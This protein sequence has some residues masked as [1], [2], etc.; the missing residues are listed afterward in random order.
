MWKLRRLLFCLPVLWLATDLRAAEPEAD[1]QAKYPAINVH[2]HCALASEEALR[3]ELAVC[4]RVGVRTVVV[5]DAGGPDGNQPDWLKLQAK[6]PERLVV[7]WKLDFQKVKE[8]TFFADIVR[9]LERAAQRGVQGVKVWKDLGMYVRD[10][11]GR[12][13]K[14]DDP[15]LDPFWARCGELK[16]PVL[17]H[18]ADPREYWQPLTYNSFHYGMRSD[19]DQHYHNPEMPRWEELIRQRDAVLK[20]HP[21]TQFI[22]AHMGSLEFDLQKLAKTFDDYP[23][24]AVDTAARQRVLG[25]LNPPAVRDFFVKYQKRILFGTDNMVLFKGRKPGAS[26][27]IAVYPSDDADWLWLDPA[28]KE[29]VRRWQD[30]EA[31]MY[32]QYF[33]YFETERLDLTDPNRS[34]GNWLRIPGIHL[35]RETL[36]HVYYANAERL[37]PGLK[38]GV[39]KE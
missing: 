32:G 29:A 38:R 2:R 10:A 36:E 25:R 27:N 16:L 21:Q 8:K 3:A 17:I 9:D 30:R 4:D 7:F 19:K 24:F 12:L 37:L 33:Q 1:Y 15:R 14:A 34:A 35:P 22:G 20:R 23:N 28:D 26:G 13:L 31:Q 5:L 6:Y 11:D 39:K 18:S